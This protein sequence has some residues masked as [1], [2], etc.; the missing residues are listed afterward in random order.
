MH[1]LL[2][3]VVGLPVAIGLFYWINDLRKAKNWNLDRMAGADPIS[4]GLESLAYVEPSQATEHA[5]ATVAAMVEASVEA[6]AE[7][8]AELVSD[9]AEVA[10]EGMEAVGEA[11]GK[12]IE[13]ASHFLHH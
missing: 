12:L 6:G 4:V 2:L 7:A 13:G 8:G 10:S 9:G 1:T 11:I 3:P 5:V